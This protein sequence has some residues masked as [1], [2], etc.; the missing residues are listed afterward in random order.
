METAHLQELISLDSTY[1]WH[2]A[3][4][5]LVCDLL[6][7]FLPAP[8][9]A[10]EG[11]IGAG[12]NLA[13]FAARGYQVTGFDT[14]PESVTYCRQCGLV[15]VRVHDLAEPWPVADASARAVVLLDVLEHIADPVSVLRHA[16]SALEPGG[17]I[18]V[19][20]PALPSLMGPWDHALG[21]L[22]RYTRYMLVDQAGEAGL[23]VTWLSHWNAFCLPA[24]WP[25][26]MIEKVSGHAR[27]AEFPRVP[28]AVNALLLRCAAIERRLIRRRSL[29]VGLSLLAVLTR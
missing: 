25:A 15:D 21:H 5:A 12:G 19:N 6:E 22:R 23:R 10:V 27:A 29:P 1:W 16:K 17:G 18:V 9:R 7:R 14:M 20:V 3:K 13:A 8:G 24:A 28:A 26:R 4:R 2:V 11:G